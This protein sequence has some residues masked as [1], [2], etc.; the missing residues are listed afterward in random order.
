MAYVVRG[1]EADQGAALGGKARA[2]A[3]LR[4]VGLPIPP[5]VALLPTAFH[6]HWTAS[7]SFFSPALPF[8]YFCAM[9]NSSE[10]VSEPLAGTVGGRG[11]FSVLT[12]VG[13][14]VCPAADCSFTAAGFVSVLL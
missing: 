5:W 3:A 4:D 1:V 7:A 12:S 9:A 11:F 13:R 6:S 14:F 10:P 2:L 8:R